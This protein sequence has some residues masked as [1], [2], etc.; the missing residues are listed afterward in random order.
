[1]NSKQ[2]RIRILKELIATKKISSRSTLL[3]ELNKRL[4]DSDTIQLSALDNYI[5]DYN[6]QLDTI[7]GYYIFKRN[8]DLKKTLS[9]IIKRHVKK[10]NLLVSEPMV[11]A[12]NVSTNQPSL[13]LLMITCS[14]HLEQI[15]CS[16]ILKTIKPI[17]YT[18]NTKSIFFYFSDR[19][20][21]DDAYSILNVN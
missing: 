1:M 19:K 20:S 14:N 9:Q 13:Y 18:I 11:L 16:K 5:K 10:Y 2:K 12:N 3:N 21:I 8:S 15:A 17:T 7:K 4:D 6:L